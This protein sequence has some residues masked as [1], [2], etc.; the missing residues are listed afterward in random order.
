MALNYQVHQLVMAIAKMETTMVPATMMVVTVVY[1]VSTQNNALTAF[2]ITRRHVQLELLILWLEMDI[3]KMKPTMLN[4]TM[5]VVIVVALVLILNIAQNANVLEDILAM[6]FLMHWLEMAF[7]MMR[8]TMLNAIMMEV[9]VVY[10]VQAQI[11][12]HSAYVIPMES[13]H[14]LVILKI[15]TTTLT[16]IGSFKFLLDKLL[17]STLSVLMLK[18]NQAAGKYV[19]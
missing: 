2:A 1:L 11:I 13:S 12:V 17:R 3:A 7:A 19:F 18:P 15:M 16:C 6:L 10:S 9:T 4:A 5:M 14:H 8:R